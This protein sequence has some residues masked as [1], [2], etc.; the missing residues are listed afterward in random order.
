MKEKKYQDEGQSFI[1]KQYES[2]NGKALHIYNEEFNTQYDLILQE[3]SP[4]I[5]GYI[6]LSNISSNEKHT[7]FNQPLKQPLKEK[8]KFND[9]LKSSFGIVGLREKLLE[10]NHDAIVDFLKKYK[11]SE[12]I[13]D[14]IEWMF[15]DFKD[16]HEKTLDE[17]ELY[18]LIFAQNHDVKSHLRKEIFI[19]GVKE[20]LSY[21]VIY[22]ENGQQYS[23][24]NSFY[25]IRERRIPISQP[26]KSTQ[27]PDFLHYING[28]PLIMIEYKTE[29]SG[30]LESLKDF[31]Y[32]ES[33]KKAPFKIALNDGRDVI[34]FSDLKFLKF[35]QGK[36]TSFHWV[37]Y[38]P[39]KKYIGQREFMNIEYLFD[40]LICQP[41]NLYT[42]CVD[43][44]SVV[45]SHSH[46]Y[47]INARIQQYYAIRDIKKTLKKV[48]DGF[49]SLPYNYEFAHA[50]RSGKTITMK[51]ISY[52]ID[53]SFKNIFN[54]IF[55]YT[56]DL[57]IKDVI[58]NELSKSGNSQI[59]VK[60]VETRLEY[61]EIIEHLS[62]LENNNRQSHGLSIY[63]V[64]MQ[65][66][67]DKEL[68]DIQRRV[69]T[70]SKI[71]NIIDE[72]HHGQTKE[73]ALIR[74]EIF[75]HASNYLFTA[76]GKSDMY[77]FYFPDN[78]KEGYSNKFTIS[79]AKQCKITVPV[80]F[81]KAEKLFNLSPH[82]GLFSEEVEKRMRQ[83]YQEGSDII[84]GDS[85]EQAVEQFLDISNPK[86]LK[87]IKKE[88]IQQSIEE[89]LK[90]VV[91]F[92]DSV[93]QGLPFAPKAI[94]YSNSVN[95]ARKAIE[96]IQSINANN[97]YMGYRFGVDFSSI[98]KICEQY[99]PG[100][101]DPSHISANFQKERNAH[102]QAQV[103]DI[104]LAVDKYQKGFDLPTLLVTFLDT[105]ISEPARMN[106]IF[107]RT[108]TKY[109]G[110]TIGYCVDLSFDAI[111]EE[112]FTQSLLLYDNAQDIGEGFINQDYLE[113][114]RSIL[115]QSFK[116]LKKALNLNSDNF[117]STMILQ[118]VLNESDVNIRQS[119]QYQFFHITK[120][121]ISNLGKM[122][123]P[124]FFKPFSMELKAIHEAFEEFKKIYADKNHAEHHKIVIN[125]DNSLSEGQY[126]TE[127]EI[128][129][130]ISQVLSFINVH[131]IK[132]IISFDY[133]GKTQEIKVDE[134]NNQQMLKKF[135]QE[136]KKNNIEKEQDELKDYLFYHH[137]NLMDL[138]TNMLIRISNNRNLVY[139]D[140]TQA[141]LEKLSTEIDKVKF[142]IQE[143]I[144]NDY[145]G[146]SFL[147]WSHQIGHQ[148]LTSHGIEQPEF[149]AYA[150]KEIYRVM[151]TL[152][153]NVDPHLSQYDKVEMTMCLFEEKE[154]GKYKDCHFGFYLKDYLSKEKP[155]PDVIKKMTIE[156]KNSFIDDKPTMQNKDLFKNYLKQTLR[157]YY[158]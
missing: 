96:F 109:T 103:I 129:S 13:S 149:I 104:L 91:N 38:L 131:H 86:V 121:I 143:K 6:P 2:Y 155:Q 67:S 47:L 77:L 130:I 3:C 105:N 114:L 56:P 153:S 32:K 25:T 33:Y 15:L 57:Q 147:F 79:N 89:K 55:M 63:I 35:K 146:N 75:P 73:T 99:N 72:A 24:K 81:L 112:T 117:T 88:M 74:Q 43:A 64:N 71:L 36:D 140:N 95:D 16:K 19:N 133:T 135:S 151:N 17:A 10:F 45:T 39:E 128:K 82:I 144:K 148:M 132:D 111:N 127:T 4:L 97:E 12:Q 22:F 134:Q 28:I 60:M 102:N 85:S 124:L 154:S 7:P 30:I 107:T 92:M 41:E 139:E 150:S 136:L 34:F 66:I 93:K 18:Q 138:I 145:Q 119:R 26:Y 158:K 8:E 14:I 61:L 80:M 156:F 11:R 5:G 152:L 123:S 100:I 101:K 108:A 21:Q 137:K 52:M 78:K 53:R 42:Y 20:S 87:L 49:Q 54:I 142:E 76:T 44:C 40:E 125:T 106:Q 68:Q 9:D 59:H 69:I 1:E 31:E 62:Q 70:S 90:A 48:S 122:G 46:H 116:D 141:E 94:I 126:I 29:D 115:A 157:Q 98:D 110:K 120:T 113:Q 51:L 27:R 118:Q 50:Q 23:N 83:E 65:K 84:G 37:H 58:H